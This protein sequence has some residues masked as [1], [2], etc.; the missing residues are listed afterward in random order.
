MLELSDGPSSALRPTIDIVKLEGFGLGSLVD[1][2]PQSYYTYYACYDEGGSET[3]CLCEGVNHDG[4]TT[5]VACENAVSR[6]LVAVATCPDP[7]GELCEGPFTGILTDD[8]DENSINDY[9]AI[10]DDFDFAA[11][12][13]AAAADK[14]GDI[15][16]DMVVYLNSILGI[17][18]VIGYSDTEL[19]EDGNPR[20]YSENPEYFN[21][22]SIGGSGADQYGP[23]DRVST[24]AGRGNG[25]KVT[26][27]QESVTGSWQETPCDINQTITFDD[28]ELLGFDGTGKPVWVP[29]FCDIRGFAQ[30]AD[31]DLSVIEFVH[32]YQIPGLR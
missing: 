31:D 29:A 11:A 9:A 14:T 8:A 2:A 20:D 22:M 24:F 5:Q 32:T 18:K 4:T 21:F 3:P 25:G 10:G 15:G 1:V 7:E 19:D 13:L 12:F 23:Y 17:N 28:I 30:M 6:K 16:V 26:V 27:L